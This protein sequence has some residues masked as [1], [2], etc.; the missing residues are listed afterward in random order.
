MIMVN[1]TG[2]AVATVAVTVAAIGVV[3]GLLYFGVFAYMWNAIVPI[4]SSSVVSTAITTIQFDRSK[5]KE[6]KKLELLVVPYGDIAHIAFTNKNGATVAE[7]D[8]MYNGMGQL[9]LDLDRVQ[10]KEDIE[11][12]TGKTN[13]T[14]SLPCIKV[15]GACVLHHDEREKTNEYAWVSGIIGDPKTARNITIEKLHL[16]ARSK[17]QQTI[18]EYMLRSE[19]I[20][21]A[22]KQA[23]MVLRTL[24]VEPGC[25]QNI[26]FVW[27]STPYVLDT[28]N[29]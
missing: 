27:P 29:R 26:E 19:N 18:R 5:I 22:K 4:F 2:K 11:S 3:W 25:E 28:D 21:L 23:E 7:V 16:E 6:I 20:E 10:C 1:F 15:G 14:V 8:Y 17:A 12:V 9:T 13:L 24:L